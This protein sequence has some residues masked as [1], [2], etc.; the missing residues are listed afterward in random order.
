L[1]F[2]WFLYATTWTFRFAFLEIDL[3]KTFLVTA[4]AGD[5]GAPTVRFLREMGHEVRALVRRDDERARKLRDLG[6]HV[7][8]ADMLKLKEMRPA[9]DGVDG[10][11]LCYSL[12][13]DGLVEATAV[14]AQAAREAKVGHV[15]NMSQKQARPDAR[16]QQTLNH[17]M[18]EQVLGWSGLPVTH[19]RVTFFAEWLLYTSHLIR[20]GRYVTPFDADSRFAPMAGIDIGRVVAG[21]LDK[22]SLHIGQTY[23]LH[24]PVE[25]SHL[26]LSQLVGRVLGKA[27]RFEQVDVEQFLTLLGAEGNAAMRSH[28]SSVRE[29]QREGLLRGQ[30]S[31]G[32]EIMGRPLTTIEQFIEMNRARFA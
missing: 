8:V 21:I 26:E 4:A 6:A 22:P 30:D 2:F 19:L 14:F 13:V 25:Y 23:Q 12:A 31:Y 9:V 28:F 27:I 3:M 24:G 18:A 17:W 7:V 20:E 32:I 10:A 11:Y 15:V 29:D 5:T 1:Y 16:S